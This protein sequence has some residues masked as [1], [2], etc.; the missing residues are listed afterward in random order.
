M[1]RKIFE[2]FKGNVGSTVGGYA[3]KPAGIHKK[4]K[5]VKTI[6]NCKAAARLYPTGF[7]A[8]VAQMPL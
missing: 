4:A 1:E 3:K 6:F 8:G 2:F 5:G 7:M